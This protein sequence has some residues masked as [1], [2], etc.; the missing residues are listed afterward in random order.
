MDGP[1]VRIAALQF[2]DEASARSAAAALTPEVLRRCV[3]HSVNDYLR[4]LDTTEYGLVPTA[5]AKSFRVRQVQSASQGRPAVQQVTFDEEVLGG[6]D[7]GRAVTLG[8]TQSGPVV[9]TVVS[10]DS[11]Q[12]LEPKSY[13]RFV[14]R[15][16]EKLA[17]TLD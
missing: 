14:E 7:N 5:T 13:S 16:T 12:L 4:S 15:S 3:V 1:F 10:A 8:V 2:P 9:A 17:A 11:A 6:Y